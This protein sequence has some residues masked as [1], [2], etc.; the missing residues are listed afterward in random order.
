MVSNPYITVRAAFV[1]LAILAVGLTGC[2]ESKQIPVSGKILL[3][4]NPIKVS[5][6]ETASVNYHGQTNKVF[7][8]GQV[9]ENGEYTMSSNNKPGMPAGSYKVT[10]TYSKPK[11]AKDPYS[12][13]VRMINEKFTNLEFTD[14]T[15]EVKDN[16]PP[17][18]YDLK[19][20]K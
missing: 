14:L 15:I 2:G 13:P 10:V 16:A 8:V 18:T 17:G 12:I 1:T 3:D 19:V 11:D 6:G 9:N 20:T 5:T 7:G 4:G